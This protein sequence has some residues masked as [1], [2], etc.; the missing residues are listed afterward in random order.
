MSDVLTRS[1][2]QTAQ[3]AT[4]ATVALRWRLILLGGLLL[5]VLTGYLWKKTIDI[6]RFDR[7]G[8]AFAALVVELEDAIGYGGFIHHYKNAILRPE[9]GAHLA[10]A[11]ESLDRALALIETVCD[12]DPARSA[13]MPL[14]NA[15]RTLL[16]YQDM[17]DVIA[18]SGGQL[19]AREVD[20]MV[21]VDDA[22]AI[23]ELKVLLKATSERL[24]QSDRAA[25]FAIQASAG[26]A[27]MLATLVLSALWAASWQRGRDRHE[28]TVLELAVAQRQIAA[29]DDRNLELQSF[30][31]AISHDLKAP[32]ETLAML[33]D[34]LDEDLRAEGQGAARDKL[35]E[36]QRTNARMGRVIDDL[37]CYIRVTG[38]ERRIEPVNLGDAARDAVADLGHAIESSGAEVRLQSLPVVA[39]DRL[40]L[41]ALL[42][43]LI[44][45]AVKYHRPGVPARV[46]VRGRLVPGEGCAEIEVI[47]NGLGVPVAHR[48]RVFGLFKRLDQ[49]VERPGIGLGLALCRRLAKNH[50]GTLTVGDA[51]SGPGARFVLR[52]PAA[53][54]ADAG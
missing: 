10:A 2:A 5:A 12:G 34:Q 3:D 39:G 23:A 28:R 31:Y 36:A 44:A 35:G 49:G 7:Q 8:A 37:L 9:D 19:S 22:G 17:L 24:A 21:R 42:Q 14:R 50:G 1:P 6:T 41:R 27:F 40:Q 46:V 53:R 32:V 25:S 18:T 15:K 52:L 13:Q 45:N 38:Q 30:A 47:D 54:M 4:T 26:A 48:E 51:P 16:R 33:F 11:R 20:A 29:L 43:N